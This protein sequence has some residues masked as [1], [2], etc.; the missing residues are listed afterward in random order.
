[1]LLWGCFSQTVSWNIT[2][3]ARIAIASGADQRSSSPPSP[4]LHSLTYHISVSPTWLPLILPLQRSSR[5]NHRT[6]SLI[7]ICSDRFIPPPVQYS[8]PS[9]S[10]STYAK[11]SSPRPTF[12]SAASSPKT[13]IRHS[14]PSSSPPHASTSL[15]KSK[16]LQSTSNPPWPK[17][18]VPFKRSAF[19][20]CPQTIAVWQRWNFTS[21]KRWSLI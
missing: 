11:E 15:P 2:T 9:A 4:G 14:T 13:P 6:H 1:M 17:R 7:N 5:A 19:A 16:N 18:P 20:A 21:W 3:R 8:P 12:F 10:D